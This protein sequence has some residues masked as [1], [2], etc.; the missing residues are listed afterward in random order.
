MR[1]DPTW[2]LNDVL[3]E[4][5]TVTG[6]RAITMPVV[7]VYNDGGSI[8]LKSEIQPSVTTTA[9]QWWWDFHISGG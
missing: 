3:V 2:I 9:C 4:N 8:S 7:A 1:R 5:N 6:D